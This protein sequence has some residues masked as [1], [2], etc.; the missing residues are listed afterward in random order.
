[1]PECDTRVQDRRN[2]VCVDLLPAGFVLQHGC[3]V[4]F[5]R[6][7]TVSEQPRFVTLEEL[8]ARKLDSWSGSP[9]R[10][11][12]KK[13][14]GIELIQVRRLPRDLAVVEAVRPLYLETWDALQAERHGAGA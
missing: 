11:H 8:I 10:R 3:R 14:D 4:P 9:N 1:V 13:T 2:G 12:K 5:P 7:T 6:P